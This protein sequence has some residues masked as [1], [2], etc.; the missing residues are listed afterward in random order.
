M[1]EVIKLGLILLV[2]TSVA[3]FVLGVTNEM[4]SSIIEERLHRE[5][6]EAIKSILPIAE[7]FNPIEGE[8]ITDKELIVEVYEGIKDDEVVGYTVKTNPNGYSGTVEVLVGFSVD[9]E[10]VGVKIGQHT[11]T[12]GLGSKIADSAYIGQFFNKAVDLGFSTTKDVP[13]TDNDIQAITGATVSSDAVVDGINA[14]GSL[15]E[16]VLRNR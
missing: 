7:E 11:E 5:N 13:A 8:G 4:T 1:R 15:F 12:P 6:V 2:I 16:E 9:G 14:A 3:A 10:I